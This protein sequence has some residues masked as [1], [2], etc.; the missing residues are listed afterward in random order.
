MYYSSSDVIWLVIDFI[1]LIWKNLNKG[2]KES[3]KKNEGSKIRKKDTQDS[4]EF[5]S[6]MEN[7]TFYSMHKIVNSMKSASNIIERIPNM[8]IHGL[9]N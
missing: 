8:Q 5:Y 1:I 2:C 6:R 9:S 3:K 7:F 4:P